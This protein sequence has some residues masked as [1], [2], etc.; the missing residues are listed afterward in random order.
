[1]TATENAVRTSDKLSTVQWR[2]SVIEVLAL[3]LLFCIPALIG[4]A[5]QPIW[6]DE[7]F[8]LFP[9][10]VSSNSLAGLLSE[11]D[12]FPGS[13]RYT[14][15]YV[16]LTA[17]WARLVPATEFAVRCVN[18]PFL[19]GTAFVA[20]AFVKR[21]PLRTRIEQWIA[22]ALLAASPFY[23]YYSYD[24]RPYAA[25]I[26]FGGMM[27]LGLILCEEGQSKGAW[28]ISLGFSL[29]FLTQPPVCLLAPVIAPAVLVACRK[30]MVASLRMWVVPGSAGTLLVAATALYYYLVRSTGGMEAW[31]GGGFIKNVIFILYEFAGFAGLGP[32]RAQLRS[33]A[34]PAGRDATVAPIILSWNDWIPVFLFAV[35]WMVLILIT[36]RQMVLSGGRFSV[37]GRSVRWPGVIFAGGLFILS[38]FFY[39][40]GYRF[41]SRHI[42]FLFLPFA[43][44]LL[45]LIAQVATTRIARLSVF[46]LLGFF[47]FS[48]G[49]LLFNPAYMREDPR[50]MMRAWSG[51]RANDPSVRLWAFYPIQSIIYYG[52]AESTPSLRGNQAFVA[53]RLGPAAYSE[54][55][56]SD[57]SQLCDSARVISL[58]SPGRDIWE[59]LLNASRGKHVI[60]AF[61]RGT[62]FDHEGLGRELLAN[63][64]AKAS[65]IAEGAF[66]ECFECYIP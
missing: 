51:A 25:L 35:I 44:T 55:S 29:A 39:R 22:L 28:L 57:V 23:V 61:N 41:L 40:M 24:L 59:R 53:K 10:P 34:P 60:V 4:M 16:L 45:G 43:F 50:V 1:M 2:L 42:S 58:D 14:P 27:A 33:L 13:I 19:L 18:L 3:L 38:L 56:G 64:A 9:V 21:L 52:P 36:I 62:E 48:S 6:I 26:L 65:K 66:V 5:R 12:H 11:F 46:L 31:G 7:G 17:V 32:T 49:Q 8:T 63:P 15:L 37:R 30:N 20:H 47:G 54:T